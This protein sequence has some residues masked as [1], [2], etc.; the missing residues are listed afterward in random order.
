MN[1]ETKNKMVRP[2]DINQ[3]LSD[4]CNFGQ[5]ISEE[6]KLILRNNMKNTKKISK[7]SCIGRKW[8]NKDGKNK[9][10]LDDEL[11][12]FLMEGWTLGCLIKK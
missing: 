3:Y 5:Y 11:N 2:E 8:I 7:P 9:R 1:K 6:R 12:N 4:G 10:V